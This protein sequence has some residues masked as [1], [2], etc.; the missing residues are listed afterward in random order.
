MLSL[1][2]ENNYLL[3][4]KKNEIIHLKMQLQLVLKIFLIYFYFNFIKA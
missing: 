4:K 2:L 1:F 3:K